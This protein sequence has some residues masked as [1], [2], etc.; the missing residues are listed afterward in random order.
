MGIIGLKILISYIPLIACSYYLIRDREDLKYLF[1]LQIIISL[2]CCGCC[3]V[4]YLLLT[5]GICS[6]N[7]SLPEPAFTRATLQARCFVGGSLLYNPQL[8]LISLPGTFVAPWQ[9]AWFLIASSFL[10]AAATAYESSFIW[11]IF[12]FISIALILVAATIS[13]QTTATLLVPIVF[14][15]LLWVTEENNKWLPYKLGIATFLCI[16]IANNFGVFGSTLDNVVSRWNYTPPQNFIIDQFNW[17][18]RDGVPLFGQGLGRSASAA[19][20][21]GEIKLIETFYPRLLYEIGWLGTLAFIGL[22]SLITV[23]TLK[24]Y[25]RIQQLPLRSLGICLWLFILFISYNTFYYPLAVEP[26]NIYYWFFAGVLLKLPML[27]RT[28]KVDQINSISFG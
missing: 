26:V 28:T 22:V 15:V 3:L 18:I 23:S 10:T 6:G 16:V 4:Q 27:D 12:G 5:T 1:R 24:T 17:I 19:R 13:G 25:R 2:V 14:F 7:V 20:K 11:R 21:L 8:K 9:W